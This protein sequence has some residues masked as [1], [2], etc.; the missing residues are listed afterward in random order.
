M[1]GS[2]GKRRTCGAGLRRPQVGRAR[3]H[4]CRVVVYFAA[5]R[6]RPKLSPEKPLGNRYGYFLS[7]SSGA[8]TREVP[9][10]AQPP[11]FFQ[12]DIQALALNELHGVIM[13]AL[14]F[15]DAE[16]RNNVG[17]VELRGCTGL[18]AETSGMGRIQQRME[19]KHLESDV[20]A[21]RFLDGFVDDPHAATPDFAED[22]VFP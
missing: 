12:N 15:A 19:G 22:A 13:N 9:S 21:Q 11:Y 1:H 14:L 18:A 16:D 20:P 17:V 8:G 4:A 6:S 2:F 7:R 5:R 10:I 3:H